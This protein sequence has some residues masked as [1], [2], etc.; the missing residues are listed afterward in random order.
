MDEGVIMVGDSWE[1][2]VQ[3]A[4]DVGWRAIHFNPSGEPIQE[5]WRTATSLLDILDMPLQA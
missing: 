4:Q 3:G 1:S 2:D 5:A